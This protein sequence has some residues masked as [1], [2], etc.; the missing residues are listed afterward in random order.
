M[1]GSGKIVM[2]DVVGD[3]HLE[4]AGSGKIKALSS[5]TVHATS[6]A[7]APPISAGSRTDSISTSRA[8]AISTRPAST[9]RS[10]STS[11]APVRST[12]PRAPPI[13]CMSTS[14]RG[15]FRLRRRSGRSAYQRAGLGQRE[16]ALLSRPVVVGRH[17][18]REDRP[19]RLPGT[20]GASCCAGSSGTAEKALNVVVQRQALTLRQ[21]QGEGFFVSR[22]QLPSC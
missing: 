15:Q 9:V 13:R 6:R 7:R 8:R 1:A 17:G 14:W 18:R 3:L 11:S 20:A 10:M 5:H 19:R 16:A 2:S 12:S 22:V 4:I 21:A